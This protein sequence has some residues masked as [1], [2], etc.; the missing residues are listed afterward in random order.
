MCIRDRSTGDP[1]LCV[2]LALRR[3]RQ[4]GYR[5]MSTMRCFVSRDSL[6]VSEQRP[7]PEPGPNQVLVK[8]AAT[9]LNRADLLQRRGLYPPPKGETDILGLEASGTVVHSN[10]QRW[11]DG[12]RVMT[13]LAGGGY[14]DYVAVDE[15]LLMPV[16]TS[17]SLQVR[18]G[19]GLPHSVGR[20]QRR[21]QRR[22]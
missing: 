21:F 4:V 10:S 2:M 22:G 7:V 18:Y 20:Q 8:V 11:K 12:D 17:M 1:R 19:C 16:P 15:G 5:W 13:L 6:V 9:A 3:A 14:A